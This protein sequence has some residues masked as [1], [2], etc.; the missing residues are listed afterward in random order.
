MLLMRSGCYEESQS[1]CLSENPPGVFMQS[2][3]VKLQ[4]KGQMVIPRS[5]REQAGL[6]EGALLEVSLVKGGRFLL[7][8]QFTLARDVFADPKKNHKALLR[9]LAAAVADVRKEAKA[10]GLDKLSGRAIRAMIVARRTAPKKADKRAA[11]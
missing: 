8:P 10:T 7:T 9:E 6:A 2:A 11:R 3:L 1:D 4:R 5:L